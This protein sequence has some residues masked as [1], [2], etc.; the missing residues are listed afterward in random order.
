MRNAATERA[1]RR[2]VV[3]QALRDSSE[4][5][6]IVDLSQE[7]GVHPNTVRF[8]VEALADQGRVERTV[9]VRTG[10]GRPPARYLARAGMDPDGPTNYRLLAAVLTNHF[11]AVSEDPAAAARTLGRTWGAAE[12]PPASTRGEAIKQVAAELAELGFRP[13][14]ADGRSSEIRLRHCPF[15]DLVPERSDVICA[16]HLGLMEGAFE[17]LAGPVTVGG[18]EPFAEPDV[19]VARLVAT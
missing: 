5:R 4:P 1:S 12:R 15:L 2:D 19:C 3:L 16:L 8:H 11:A 9:G 6:T 18:L 13:D 7:L 17:A 14:P 10:L